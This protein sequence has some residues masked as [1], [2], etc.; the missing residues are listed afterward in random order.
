MLP[1]YRRLKVRVHFQRTASVAEARKR[2]A[3]SFTRRRDRI[4][5]PARGCRALIDFV[6]FRRSASHTFGQWNVHT[7]ERGYDPQIA[8]G[9]IEEETSLC[10]LRHRR[11]SSS[12][13]NISLIHTN[14]T[15]SFRFACSR[16]FLTVEIK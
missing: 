2:Y 12:F 6:P 13:E 8:P 3:A 9:M 15:S 1:G 5:D 4:P 16:L 11:Y 10:P 14:A 7:L